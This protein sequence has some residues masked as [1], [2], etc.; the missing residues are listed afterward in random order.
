MT[1]KLR[2]TRN[3]W[4]CLLA[5]R[6]KPSLQSRPFL[7][8]EIYLMSGI[9]LLWHPASGATLTALEKTGWVERAEWKT[10]GEGPLPRR[11]DG[12]INA[13]QLT[14]AGRAAVAACPPVFPGDKTHV[15]TYYSEYGAPQ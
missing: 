8:R 15:W 2:L 12:T 10:L 1:D 13:W 7:A 14:D 9:R 4:E 5:F 11:R 6:D 3:R